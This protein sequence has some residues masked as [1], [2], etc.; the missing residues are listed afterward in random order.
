MHDVIHGCCY[1]TYI[2]TDVSEVVT[3]TCNTDCM[4]NSTIFEPVCGP[5]NI[6][7]FSPCRAGCEKSFLNVRVCVCLC[8]CMLHVACTMCHREVPYISIR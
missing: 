7:Y 2:P 8:V 1:S 5:D 4:C 3:A 6:T